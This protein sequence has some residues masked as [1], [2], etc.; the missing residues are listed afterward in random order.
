VSAGGALTATFHPGDVGPVFSD[1]SAVIGLQFNH[2]PLRQFIEAADTA[3]INYINSAITSG[4][5][6]LPPATG[7][8]GKALIVRMTGT[9]AAEA[10]IPAFIQQADVAGLPAA[11]A[12]LTANDAGVA[13]NA[14]LSRAFY[15]DLF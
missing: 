9:P 13:A 14:V 3:I 12:T 15:G 5:L 11:L 8:L 7:N 1:G 10:W 4:S 2:L 6:D